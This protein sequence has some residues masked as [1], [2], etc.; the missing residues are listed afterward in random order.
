MLSWF[1]LLT[2]WFASFL[3]EW[4]ANLIVRLLFVI[5]WVAI[6]IILTI[7]V[8]PVVYRSLRLND[9]WRKKK[10][11][12]KI[13][14]KIPLREEPFAIVDLQ[15]RGLTIAKG[16][17]SIL[18]ALIWFAVLMILLDGFGIDVTVILASAGVIGVAIAFGTQAL[19]KDFISGLFILMEKTFLVGELV[20]IDGFTGVVKEIGLR[21]TKLEDWK[22]AYLIINNGN[23]GSVVNFSRDYS[24][25]VVDLVLNHVNDYQKAAEAIREF[26][27]LTGQ[28]YPEMT[29]PLRYVGIV[30]S[31]DLRATF[32]M[33]AKCRPA[34]HFGIE[35]S[36][37]ADLLAFAEE[38]G[39]ILPFVQVSLVP[40]E[41][42]GK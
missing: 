12:R 32:R 30:E 11:L 33:A 35:R 34:E 10:P 17:V 2:P 5:V 19:V 23:I 41:P 38:R 24:V 18:Q 28:K 21:T 42:H 20:T 14:E 1:E 9:A 31:T 13:T 6:A 26:V 22:G 40:G 36:L 27:T 29:E 25:A 7:I 15:K 39:L 3:G 37:R 16:L 8:K 4:V